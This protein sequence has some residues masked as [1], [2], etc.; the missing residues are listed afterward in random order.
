MKQRKIKGV[1]RVSLKEYFLFHQFYSYYTLSFH[2]KKNQRGQ[3]PT[4]QSK[5][6]SFTNTSM[7]L[8]R[9]SGSER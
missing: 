9:R 2:M 1:L 4:F 8:M 3:N 7:V 5:E 6:G